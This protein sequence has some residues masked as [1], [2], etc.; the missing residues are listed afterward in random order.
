MKATTVTTAPTPV[1]VDREQSHTVCGGCRAS[2]R[3]REVLAFRLPAATVALCGPC[4]AGI[5][6]AT[7]LAR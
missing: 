3:D 7:L 5:V 1:I 6:A 4:I 2:S